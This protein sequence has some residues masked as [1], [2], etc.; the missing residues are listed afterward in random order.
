MQCT[1]T[2]FSSLS[3]WFS[4]IYFFKIYSFY[5]I[6]RLELNG[7]YRIGDA[8]VEVITAMFPNLKHLTM[9]GCAFCGDV[10]CRKIFYLK[11]LQSLQIEEWTFV[12]QNGIDVLVS[13]NLRFLSVQC[14]QINKGQLLIQGSR[15]LL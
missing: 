1:L 4:L 15:T 9:I 12:T 3:A 5:N 14:R 11:Q 13:K 2:T 8:G 6:F 7:S 10:S